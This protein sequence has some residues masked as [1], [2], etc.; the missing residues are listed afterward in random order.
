MAKSRIKPKTETTK[1]K[2]AN[3]VSVQ[4]SIYSNPETTR[5]SKTYRLGSDYIR[6]VELLSTGLKKKKYEII[7][8]ALDMI[9][10]ENKELLEILKRTIA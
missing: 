9:F 7:E 2:L 5:E 3:L 6:N 4:A 8:E 10:K 1:K